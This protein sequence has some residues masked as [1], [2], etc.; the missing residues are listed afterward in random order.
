MRKRYDWFNATAEIYLEPRVR[1]KDVDA[2]THPLL[3]PVV[4]GKDGLVCLL[5]DK[6]DENL[7]EV[8]GPQLK[9]VSQCAVGYNNIDVD[10]CTRRG[11]A[12]GFTPGVLSDTTADFA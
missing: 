8:A 9:V 11:I 10:A 6:I 12:V 3:M 7:L 1:R 2:E 4:K 5:T